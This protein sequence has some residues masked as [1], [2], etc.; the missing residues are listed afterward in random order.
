VDPERALRK[1]NSKF[2]RRFR[3][4]ESFMRDAGQPITEADLDTLD[5]YWEKAKEQEVSR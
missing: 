1:G 4:V 3:Q 5:F 2:T